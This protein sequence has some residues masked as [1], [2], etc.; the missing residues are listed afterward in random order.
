MNNCSYQLW[1]ERRGKIQSKKGGWVVGKG[2][3]NHGYSMMDDLVGKVSYMQVLV[4]NATGRLPE[5][6]LADWFEACH[7][8]M[9]WPDPRI[10][11]NQIGALGGTARTSVVAAITAG[12]LAADAKTYGSKPLLQGVQF[13]QTAMQD[14]LRGVSAEEIVGNACAKHRGKPNITGFARPLAKGDER[15]IAMERVQKQL[16]FPAGEHLQL[17]LQIE[18]ILLE[19]FNESM[20]INGYASAFLSDMGYSAEEVYRIFAIVVNSGITACYVDTRDK[21]P[22]TFLPLRCTDIEYTGMLARPVP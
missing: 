7:I 17:A 14:H 6:P 4:L 20:N 5:R 18:S 3:F 8:C 16:G 9:S 13:I 2:I 15:V 22:D 19:R 12:V 11:C 1:D 21:A 10:W